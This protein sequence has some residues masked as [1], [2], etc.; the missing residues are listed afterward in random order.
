MVMS[1]ALAFMADPALAASVLP[2]PGG[3]FDVPAF[4]ERG[5]TV[6]LIA[7]LKEG[8]DVEP[9]AGARQDARGQ[10]RVGHER[11]RP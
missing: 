1:R 5:G 7:A 9:A 3:G 2:S 11:Q 6:Y 10:R 4:L 8:G